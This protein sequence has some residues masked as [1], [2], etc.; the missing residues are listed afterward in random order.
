MNPASE[1]IKDIIDADSALG[2]AFATDLFIGNEPGS[3]KNVVTI[4]DTPGFPPQLNL[5]KDEEYLYPSIQIQVRNTN[6]STGWTLI[7]DIKDFLHGRS[8]QTI[9]ATVYEVIIC[10]GEP[11]LLDFDENDNA[12]FVANFDIQRHS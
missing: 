8:H 5:D 1:D 10:S 4:F 9:N 12:R 7:N 6:Y 11:F 3:P 2:L